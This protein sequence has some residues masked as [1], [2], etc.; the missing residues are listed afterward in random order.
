MKKRILFFIVFVVLSFCFSTVYYAFSP[1]HDLRC[2]IIP[3]KIPEETTYIDLLIPIKLNDENYTPLNKSNGEKFGISQNSEIVNYNENGYMSYT[4][5]YKNSI[6]NIEPYYFVDFSCDTNVYEEN[7]D[8]FLKVEEF[9]DKFSSEPRY[10]IDVPLNSE[11]EKTVDMLLEI[12][13]NS[14][15]GNLLVDFGDNEEHRFDGIRS[16]YKCIKMAYLDKNG[17]ILSI[18]NFA[19]IKNIREI[20]RGHPVIE[21]VLNGNELSVSFG[22]GPP[23]GLLFIFICASII[24][25]VTV[26]IV[27]IVR[28]AKKEHCGGLNK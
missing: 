13:W 3:N 18:S 22:F 23:F 8:L 26:I 27:A 25:T 4:F 15:K 10:L 6:S 7:K 21:P 2:E 24:I 19:K 5:H 11:L 14:G 28:S 20:Y 12:S 16:T 17:N 1:S 9:K